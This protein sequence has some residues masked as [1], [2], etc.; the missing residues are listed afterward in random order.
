[1]KELERQTLL[2]DR[3]AVLDLLAS[4][5]ESD[6][7]GRMSFQS[8]LKD[9]E[10]QLALL[11]AQHVTIGSVALMFGGGPVRGSRTIDASFATRTIASFTDMVAKK[12]ASEEIGRLGSR[13]K[14]PL[15]SEVN[16]SIAD[17]VRGSVGFVLEESPKTDEIADT[18]VKS[19]I[20]EITSVIVSA[21]SENQEAFEDAVELLDSR[22]L[23]SLR[24]FFDVLD[25][26]NATVRIVEENRDAQLDFK[27]IRRARARVDMIEI[28]EDD[29]ESV[30]GELLGVLPS[31]RRFEMRLAGTGDVIKGTVA[32]SLTPKYLR[33]IETPDQAPVGRIWRT[34]MRIRE[35]KERNRPPRKLYTLIGLLEQVNSGDK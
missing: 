3:S 33:L 9:I 35:I 1:M 6:P 24:D 21:A 30:V 5:P 34:K 31:S 15:R 27:A 23:V 20:D 28:S 4:I 13:G 12:V 19:A 32:A 11:D 10:Q 16:L 25:K 2:A 22:I 7:L 18:I 14:V 17:I 29:S 26:E 8:R